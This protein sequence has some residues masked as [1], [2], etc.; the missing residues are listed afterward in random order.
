MLRWGGRLVLLAAGLVFA[1][2]ALVM[3]LLMLAWWVARVAWLK[4]TGRPVVPFVVRVAPRDAFRRAWPQRTGARADDRVV[5]VEA[6][7]LP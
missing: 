2:S 6:R 3:V 1:A 4:L 5:D 7:P